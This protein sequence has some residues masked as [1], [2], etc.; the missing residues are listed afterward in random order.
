MMGSKRKPSVNIQPWCLG[1]LLPSVLLATTLVLPGLALDSLLCNYCPLQHKGK[2]CPNITSQCLPDERCS[3]SMGR[4]GPV[5]IL[6]AQ[7][8]IAAQL[9]GSHEIISYRGVGYNVSHSCCCRD[10][11]NRP[12]KSDT[13]L[14]RLLGMT[15]DKPDYTNFGNFTKVIIEEPWD[16]CVNYTSSKMST[17]PTTAS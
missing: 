8:C 13:S 4:Y 16:S 6:S 5:H 10:Q 1:W 3:S 2:P 7:G 11:C 14:K 17:P 9:C 15:T 12:P